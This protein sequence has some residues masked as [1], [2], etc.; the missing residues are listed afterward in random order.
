MAKHE[1]EGEVL[2]KEEMKSTKGG[3]GAAAA[4]SQAGLSPAD[5]K[6]L[7]ASPLDANFQEEALTAIPTQQSFN[8]GV[9][10]PPNVPLKK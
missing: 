9:N 5:L 6:K 8:V 4:A 10:A 2:S 1:S 3:L 7:E